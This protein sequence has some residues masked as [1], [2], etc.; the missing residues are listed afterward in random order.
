MAQTG[1]TP[2][3][4]YYSTTAAAAP[5]AGNL[6]AGELALNT[7]DEKLYFK[8]AAGTVKLLASSAGASGDV[9]GP[10]S[11]TDN[12]IPTYDGTTGKLIKNNSGVTISSGT[13]TAT[14][15]SGPLNGT[16]GATTPNTG[17][18]TTLSAS[19]VATFSA[20]SAAAPSITTSGDTNTGIFFPAADT[21][22]FTEGGAEA[23]RIDSSGNLGLGVT[24]S[25]WYSDAKAMQLG[26]T[27]SVFGRTSNEIVGLSS[28]AY[29]D[30]ISTASYKYIAS[31]NYATNYL[32]TTGQH[33]WFT[34]P[35]GTAG[36]AIS[37]TTAMTLDASGNLGIGTSSPARI[38]N[39]STSGDTLV[40]ITGGAANARGVE[41]YDSSINGAQLYS[42]GTDLRIFT[43]AAGAS[44]ERMR[45]DSSGNVGIGVTPSAWDAGQRAIELPG[46]ISLSW[47]GGPQMFLMN[48]TYYPSGGPFK[49]YGSGVGASYY[50]QYNGG[51]AWY[52]APSGTAG[53]AI[54]FTQAMTLFASGSLWVGSSSEITGGQGFL[55][56]NGASG[57]GVGPSIGFA[58]NGTFLGSIG[59]QSRISG[60][61]TSQD[62]FIQAQ[63]ASNNIGLNSVNGYMYFQTGSTERARIDSSGKLLLGTTGTIDMGFGTQLL[64]VRS[65]SASAAIFDV[66]S[67]VNEPAVIAI[68]AATSGY[69]SS[70][71]DIR[72]AMASG[73]GF[74]AITYYSDTNIGRFYVLGNGDVQNTNNSYAGISDA[75][76]KENIVDAT[77][78]LQSLMDVRVRNYNFIGEDQ[79]QLGV[80]AQELEAVFPALVQETT[81][82]DA[83]GND[84][85]TTTKAVKYSVFV[86]M[87]IKAVQEQ[88]AIIEALK[89]RLDAAGL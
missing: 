19:G 42:V 85:G 88:Q 84:L 35:S 50:Y 8:N 30:A 1:Y 10:A 16:V 57:S 56:L 18:F 70:V 61:G 69:T 79:K 13:I 21:I 12:A 82:R 20:G 47:A 76:L 41:F 58:Q 44:S 36:N 34:A 89:A 37:F 81:D 75:K 49:Y 29:N 17:A 15:F 60:S 2:I 54:T 53:N 7:Q 73:T 86:P 72:T 52:N 5:T 48:N 14:G 22:A 43:V 77:P 87:L 31:G 9:V 62:I 63:A 78:K 59:Q 27:G 26:V 46:G 55:G 65:T 33:Q 64:S 25:A 71:V 11:A 45:I 28:N 74:R 67:T 66:A 3:S 4:L 23:M 6:V 32:Q 51:H 38:L 40:R 68:A 80:V 83:D 24:P 39:V